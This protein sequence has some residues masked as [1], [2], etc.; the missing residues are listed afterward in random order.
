[1][2][3]HDRSR[4]FT[5]LEVLLAVTLVAL[6][7]LSVGVALQASFDSYQ[8]N[9]RI[10]AATQTARSALGRMSREIR[11]ADAINATT[12]AVT[13]LPPGGGGW[14]DQIEYEL[15]GGTLYYRRTVSGTESEYVLMG[16]DERVSVQSFE[17]G[18]QTGQDA[19]GMP[20]TKTVTI[21]LVLNVDGQSYPVATSVSP[22]RNQTF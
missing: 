3:S 1:M 19:E 11:N 7:L 17:I 6:L 5:V 2:R 13:I 20:C 22:R 12:N 21:R 15:S 8:E 18:S 14:P 4:G 16:S 9:D 10:A